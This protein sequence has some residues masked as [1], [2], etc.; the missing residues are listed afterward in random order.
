MEMVQVPTEILSLMTHTL[1]LE[2]MEDLDV[3]KYRELSVKSSKSAREMLLRTVDATDE[4]SLHQKNDLME[5][6][7]ADERRLEQLFAPLNKDEEQQLFTFLFNGYKLVYKV[8][9]GSSA[10]YYLGMPADDKIIFYAVD[11]LK[12]PKRYLLAN[13]KSF[14]ITKT[15][16]TKFIQYLDEKGVDIL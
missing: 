16:M 12:T 9:G 6:A 14:Y 7:F 8:G 1:D 4:L 2:S 11:L 15:Y 10:T 5:R 13:V 3:D